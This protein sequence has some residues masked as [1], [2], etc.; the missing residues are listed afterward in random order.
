MGLCRASGNLL[1]LPERFG[2]YLWINSIWRACFEAAKA[3]NRYE[4]PGSCRANMD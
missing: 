1:N 2:L 3:I 4:Q